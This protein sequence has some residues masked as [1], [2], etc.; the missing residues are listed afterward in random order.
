MCM[1]EMKAQITQ[2]KGVGFYLHNEQ[3]FWAF[4]LSVSLIVMLFRL[5][6]HDS[7]QQQ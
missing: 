7:K 2:M 6:K 4:V 5:N 1:R 3:P